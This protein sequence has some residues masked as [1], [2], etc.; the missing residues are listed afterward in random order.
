MRPSRPLRCVE[1]IEKA[2]FFNDLQDSHESAVTEKISKKVLISVSKSVECATCF[3]SDP[4][5]L[6]EA[7]LSS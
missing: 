7:E 6:F 2:L 1:E 4:K 5:G 3:E